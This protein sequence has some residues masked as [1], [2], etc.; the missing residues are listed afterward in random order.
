MPKTITVRRDGEPDLRFTGGLVAEIDSR[1]LPDSVGSGTGAD[2]WEE[3]RLWKTA[4]GKY[5]AGRVEGEIDVTLTLVSHSY[6]AQVCPDES[7]LIEYFGYTR[8]AKALYK[9]AGFDTAEDVE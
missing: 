1:K 3:L 9:A 8:T 4:S 7:A 5:V 2:S 6:S